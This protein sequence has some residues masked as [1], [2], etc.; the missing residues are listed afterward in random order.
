[1]HSGQVIA[2][3]LLSPSADFRLNERIFNHQ[4][5]SIKEGSLDVRPSPSNSI[6]HKFEQEAPL[7]PLLKAKANGFM[8]EKKTIENA[9]ARLNQI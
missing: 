8:K 4:H 1:M 5:A 6:I 7:N 9:K 3:N 2:L